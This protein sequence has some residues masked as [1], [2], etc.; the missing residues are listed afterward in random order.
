MIAM[1]ESNPSARPSLETF[2]M[3]WPFRLVAAAQPRPTPI[4]DAF[5]EPEEPGLSDQ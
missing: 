3:F 2:L 4:S 5:D 1:R